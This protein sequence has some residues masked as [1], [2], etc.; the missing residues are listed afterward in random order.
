MSK[1]EDGGSAFPVVNAGDWSYGATLR[2]Y[3]AAK[4][5]QGLLANP[6]LA[7][8]IVKRGGC[9]SGWIEESAFGFADAMLKARGYS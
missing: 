8:E 1:I 9:S 3:F 5:L 2:D 4:A 6:K 7:P